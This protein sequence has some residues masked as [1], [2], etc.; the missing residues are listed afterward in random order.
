MLPKKKSILLLIII[1]FIVNFYC[2]IFSTKNFFDTKLTECNRLANNI[3]QEFISIN[4]YAKFTLTKI[5]QDI[6]QKKI[7]KP[8]EISLILSETSK[9][10]QI[11]NNDLSL[12]TVLYWVGNDNHLLASSSGKITKPIDLSSRK[13]LE[14]LHKNSNKILFSP[15]VVGAMSGENILPVSLALISEK[16]YIIGTSLLSVQV[17]ELLKKL[18]ESQI[19][20]KEFAVLF[21]NNILISSD[22]NLENIIN[23]NIENKLDFATTQWQIIFSFFKNNDFLLFEKKI[24]DFSV[25]MVIKKHSLLDDFKNISLPYLVQTINIM[26]LLF[27]V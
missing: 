16:G 6:L 22:A 7:Y 13:Y 23:E 19:I 14:N 4:D 3:L 25:I 1:I 2:F 5:N 26:L 27:L 20:D 9:L 24:Q 10:G 15:S 11:K 8:E 12:F 17:K 18:S 21:Q